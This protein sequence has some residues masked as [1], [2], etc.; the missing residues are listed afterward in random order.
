MCCFIQGSYGRLG[1]GNSDSQ[2]SMKDINTFPEGVMIRKLANSKGSD[3]HSLAIDMSGRVYSWGDGNPTDTC[4]CII[5]VHVH[6]IL[7]R[8]YFYKGS[9]FNE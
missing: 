6:V 4:T 9:K 5:G 8:A 1:V 7:Y 2:P 3:G